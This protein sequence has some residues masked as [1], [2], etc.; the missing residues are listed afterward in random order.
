MPTMQILQLGK[1]YGEKEMNKPMAMKSLIFGLFLLC[2]IAGAHAENIYTPIPAPTPAPFGVLD[3]TVR[4]HHNII[5]Q[6]MILTSFTNN[7]KTSVYLN[8]D[9]TYDTLLVPGDY[10]LILLDGNGG[11]RESRYFTI[12]SGYSVQISFIGHGVTFDSGPIPAPTPSLIPTEVPTTEPTLTPTP[13][14]SPT[15][16]PIPTPIPTPTI[17]P[18][19]TPIPT[20]TV[21]PTITITPTITATPTPALCCYIKN[22]NGG[23]VFDHY[24]SCPYIYMRQITDECGPGEP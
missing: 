3:V 11:Q 1:K 2:L 13:T 21:V 10:A 20:V 9:G 7:E 5:S 17:T 12:Q 16:S 23:W 14:V 15:L 19:I 18:T 8:P 4:C 22:D 24:G 6:E